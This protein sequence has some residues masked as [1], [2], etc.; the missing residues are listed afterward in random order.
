M[1]FFACRY[2][3]RFWKYFRSKSKVVLNS[4]EFWMFLPFQVLRG[5]ASHKLYPRYY[6]HLA[7]FRKVIIYLTA[8][9]I[10]AHSVNFKPIFDFL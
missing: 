6:S 1:P 10:S 8:E 7:N 2:F 9:V 5:R 4:T 3:Y